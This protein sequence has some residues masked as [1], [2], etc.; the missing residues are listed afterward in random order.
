MLSSF[1]VPSH[2]DA[3]SFYIHYVAIIVFIYNLIIIIC[4]SFAHNMCV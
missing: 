2:A 4:L 3:I 1:I